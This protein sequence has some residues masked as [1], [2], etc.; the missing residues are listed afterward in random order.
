MYNIRQIIREIIEEQFLSE[1]AKDFFD[2]DPN[3]GLVILK[4]G[5]EQIWLHLFNFK[6]KQCVGIITILK[7]SNRAWTVTTVA[8][9]KG[10]GPLMYKI[11]MM[12][13]YPA[14]IC[15]DRIASS[16][17]DDVN[18]W[19][20]FLKMPSEIKRQIIKP[21]EF[22]YKEFIDD[23]EKEMVLNQLYSRPMSSWFKKIKERGEKLMQDTNVDK[24]QI[25]QICRDYF[26]KRYWKI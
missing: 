20:K 15:S 10:F 23:E 7:I 1:M 25:S 19:R 16:S 9:E 22:E 4:P 21:G 11:A 17:E 5:S 24:H 26:Q 18:V 3:V 14:G 12:A 13:A 2:L 6:T 8:A